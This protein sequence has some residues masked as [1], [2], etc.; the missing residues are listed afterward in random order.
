M[1]GSRCLKL[2]NEVMTVSQPI[3]KKEC[4]DRAGFSYGRLL[5]SKSSGMGNSKPS[6]GL[7][8]MSSLED[9]MLGG[10]SRQQP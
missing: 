5:H 2:W 10:T 3:G 8:N 4:P 7:D 9:A 6:S 1:L